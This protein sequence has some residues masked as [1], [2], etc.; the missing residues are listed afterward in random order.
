MLNAAQFAEL[1]NEVYKTQVYPDPASLGEGVNWQDMVLRNAPIQNHQ[2]TITGGSEKTQL[3]LSANYF[4]QDGIIINSAFK[5]YS[6]RLNLDHQIS[7]RVKLGTSMFGSYNINDRIPTGQSSLDAPVVTNS[8]VGAALAAPPTLQA[9]D[10]EGRIYPF[11]DQYN[12]RYREVVN[13]LGLAEIMNQNKTRRILTNLY[14]QAN[15]LN[16]LTY[17]ASFNIDLEKNYMAYSRLDKEVN[18]LLKY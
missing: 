13:P 5:R 10:A 6:V 15:L 7:E 14:A 17:R 11:G 2:L 16:G 9:Y 12:S 1:E 8:I 18:E 3:A 4:N